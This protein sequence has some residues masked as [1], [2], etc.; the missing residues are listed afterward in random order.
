MFDTDEGYEG[1]GQFLFGMIGANEGNRGFEMDNRTNG[2]MNSQ[3]RSYP[4][5]YNVTMVGSGAGATA[6]NDQMFRLREGTG[7]DFRQLVL[8]DGKALGVR[9]T[10][11]ATL[12][13]VPESRN[14]IPNCII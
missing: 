6:D 13:L 9:I 11:D 5:F 14:I 7:G 2:D 8:A 10:D 3:P 1:R 12:A 4:Q